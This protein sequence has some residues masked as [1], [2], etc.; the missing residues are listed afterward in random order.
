[1]DRNIRIAK[2]LVKLA[3]SLVAGADDFIDKTFPDYMKKLNFREENNGYYEQEFELSHTVDVVVMIGKPS[4]DKNGDYTCEIKE[5]A[6][7]NKHEDTIVFKPDTFA[8]QL[9]Q[10][11]KKFPAMKNIY[12]SI[13]YRKLK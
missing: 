2:E 4:A 12:Q 8:D 3:K 11:L 13:E 10:C 6:N 1:M 5:D 9:E 7:G